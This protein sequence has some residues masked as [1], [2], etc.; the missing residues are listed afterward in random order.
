MLDRLN[1]PKG[2]T[3]GVLKDGHTMEELMQDS[4]VQ[5]TA[6]MVAE[7]TVSAPGYSLTWNE[8][9]SHTKGLFSNGET[10]TIPITNRTEGR[11]L[12]NLWT[13]A[14]QTWTQLEDYLVSN[15][16][17]VVQLVKVGGIDTTSTPGQ[18]MFTLSTTTNGVV[19]T[20]LQ[21][22]STLKFKLDTFGL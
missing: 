3:I 14:Q 12:V 6:Y 1:Q 7:P 15:R 17:G 10:L 4:K 18:R 20:V 21:D 19:I 9:F 16:E 8:W 22:N 5:R 13:S 2:S 11:L